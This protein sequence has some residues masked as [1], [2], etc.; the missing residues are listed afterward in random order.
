MRSTSPEA[1]QFEQGANS[2]LGDASKPDPGAA[3]VLVD[4]LDHTKFNVAGSYPA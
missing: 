3:A 2:S 1:G 4:E